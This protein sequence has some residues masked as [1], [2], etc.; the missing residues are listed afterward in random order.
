MRDNSRE[1]SR[2]SAC[3][4]VLMRD[5][6]SELPGD[7]S[8]ARSRAFSHY[9]CPNYLPTYIHF[10]EIISIIKLLCARTSARFRERVLAREFWCQISRQNF[11]AITLARD[12]AHFL[13]LTVLIT[14]L[15]T[16]IFMQLFPLLKCLARE[17]ARDFAR[18]FSRE[19]SGARYPVRT[20]GR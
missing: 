19:S 11:R 17:L 10:H 7:N 20:S 8:R 18:E 3:A 9:N 13:A 6:T 14:Y 5:I 12:L 1:I 16:Y 15:P 4:R 2:A